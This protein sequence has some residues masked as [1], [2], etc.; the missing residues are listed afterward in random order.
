MSEPTD[1]Q[2]QR[3]LQ[4]DAAQVIIPTDMWDKIAGRLEQDVRANAT[5]GHW[6]TR[7]GN[8]VLLGVCAA[9]FGVMALHVSADQLGGA[10]PLSA[11]M[12]RSA[13][14]VSDRAPGHLL[15]AGPPMAGS[16]SINEAHRTSVAH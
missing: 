13:A 16:A 4:Q 6:R 2:I 7:W 1:R 9:A 11:T 5:R 3:V 12:G 8:M 15:Q 14:G 10:S